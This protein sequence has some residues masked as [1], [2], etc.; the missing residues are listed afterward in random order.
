MLV[1]MIFCDDVD[2]LAIKCMLASDAVAAALEVVCQAVTQMQIECASTKHF[3]LEAHRLSVIRDLAL[4][5]KCHGCA[6]PEIEE[7]LA[8]SHT[9]RVEVSAA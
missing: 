9:P 7:L 8:R 1:V 2:E 6:T 5:C 4:H 3:R